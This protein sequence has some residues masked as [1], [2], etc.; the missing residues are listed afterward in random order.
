MN[1]IL[2][3]K[4]IFI[5]SFIILEII[6]TTGCATTPVEYALTSKFY[7][8]KGQHD[9]AIRNAREG[10]ALDPV[11]APNWY[12]LGVAYYNKG[13]NEEAINSFKKVIELRSNKPQLQSS[14][15]FLGLIYH[16]RGDYKE[17]IAQ[18]G[19]ALELNPADINSI[20][21]IG[22]SYHFNRNFDE[23]I[24]RFNKALEMN[25]ADVT[26][27][28]FRGW[29]FYHKSN[30]NEA[31]KDF[32][33]AIDNIKPEQKIELQNALRGKGF[34]YL[35][36]GE[37]DTA[38]NMI[39]Q[40]K[41]ASDYDNNYDLS[42]MY[43]VMG[44]KEKAWELRGGKGALGITVRDYNA[45]LSS[46]FDSKDNRKGAGVENT[47]SG[48]PAEKAGLLARDVIIKL[49]NT[50]ILNMMDFVKSARTLE[51][52][53]TARIKILRDGIEKDIDI[54]VAF[55]DFLMES[56]PLIAPV[57]AKR[58]GDFRMAELK[59]PVLVLNAMSDVDQLPVVAAKSNKNAYAIVIGI[60]K[61]RKNLP[62]ADFAGNDALMVTNYLAKAMGY[63]EENIVTLTNENATKSDFEKYFEKWLWNNVEKK[64]VVF[65][66][67]SG[68]GAPNPGSGDAYLVPYD[69]DPSFIE[70]T[71]YS[72]KRLYDALGK[73]PAKEIIVTLDSC[74]SGAGGRS[75][76][77]KGARPLVINLQNNAVVPKNMTVM[78][79]S[80][81]EQISST[82]DEKSHGLFTY[83]MLKGIK[84]EDFIRPD[85]SIRMDDL[86]GYIKPQ[87]ERI[88]RKHYNN[89]QSP[90]LIGAN[91]N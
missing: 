41:S 23:A 57:M 86:F 47:M 22:R 75:V 10:I 26:D 77:A 43:Y 36:L 52:G 28:E 56:A 19:K 38:I 37:G 76:L 72:L 65:V 42:L 69:G 15:Y 9:E 11:Y 82:Y 4:F 74:F 40:A 46:F 84:N 90:Q 45:E 25:P 29:S 87:V 33:K 91:K 71:G 54:K 78:S 6:S 60:E 12:W 50:T 63:P 61:Y 58:K 34:S 24:S 20:K 32:N 5:A 73:L 8:E 62:K 85:G 88:A 59:E 49:N 83:F 89:E 48:G 3:L 21:Y 53:T 70:Q 80:S 39:K 31:I 44:N 79:A 30:Y 64:S 13:Q 1:K 14:Y 7:Y 27:L 55:A 66:Y 67:F 51:P 68:H 35:G 17:A 18:L 16:N 2:N 81:G